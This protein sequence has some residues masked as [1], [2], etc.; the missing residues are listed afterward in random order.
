MDARRPAKGFDEG[1]SLFSDHTIP[2]SPTV[3]FVLPAERWLLAINSLIGLAAILVIISMDRDIQ[4]ASFL[5]GFLATLALVG[6]GGYIRARKDSPRLA[7]GLIGFAL[8]MSFIVVSGLFIFALL[9]LPHPLYDNRLIAIDA[10][11][12]YHWRGFVLW[13][14]DFPLISLAL[15]YLYGNSLL[16]LL[17]VIFVLAWYSKPTALHRF[18]LTGMVTMMVTVSIWWFWPTVG[19]SA[20]QDIPD[21]V[22]KAPNLVFHPGYGAQL[23]ELVE[24]GPAVIT[25]DVIIGI[26]AFPSYHMIM[27]CMVAWYSYRTI[28]FYPAI[29]AGLGMIPATL[30]HGGHHLIDL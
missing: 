7:L 10:T 21:Q 9:P 28:L 13:L 8:Y 19:P 24:Q 6:V 16:Q 2:L 3:R 14:A 5:I 11:L 26:I 27:A 30:S 25:P 17:L 15:A 20:F 29:I 4:P 22:Q 23:K 12:G 18:L 1:M